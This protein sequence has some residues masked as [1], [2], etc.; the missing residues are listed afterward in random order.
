MT[1]DNSTAGTLA[2]RPRP[3]AS[4][5][6]SGAKLTIPLT[7]GRV[8][9]GSDAHF[10]PGE[11][12][13]TAW[14]A[15][16]TLAGLLKPDVICINGDAADFAAI[17]KHPK[18]GWEKRWGVKDEIA[19]VQA[20]FREAERAAPEAQLVFTRGNH[21]TRMDTALSNRAPEF[22]GLLGTR[23]MDHFSERWAHPWALWLNDDLCIKHRLAGGTHAAYNNA[24]KSGVNIVCGHTHSLK[25]VP[26]SDYRGSRFGVDCGTLA[27]PQSELFE[28]YLECGPTDWRSGFV[29]LTI[30]AGQLQ[31]PEVIPVTSEERGTIFFRGQ[32]IAV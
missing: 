32:T 11:A 20:R 30:A 27:N 19:E 22:D 1:Q 6:R 25:V 5:S 16:C 10:S 14:R 18:I 2:E 3:Q 21:D 24:V 15:F 8:L 13:T 7:D 9:V 31:W 17:S 29:L 4:Q 28:N 26:F 23:L 12:V